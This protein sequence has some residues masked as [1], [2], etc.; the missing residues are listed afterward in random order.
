M[1]GIYL[2]PHVNSTH[3]LI[4]NSGILVICRLRYLSFKAHFFLLFIFYFFFPIVLLLSLLEHLWI[5]TRISLVC[6]SYKISLLSDNC[7]IPC[8]FNDFSECFTFLLPPLKPDCFQVLPWIFR[9]KLS[10]FSYIPHQLLPEGEDSP[11]LAVPFQQSIS[12]YTETKTRL[13]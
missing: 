10:V 5:L 8:K 12:L 6:L 1:C 7:N 3:Y 11:W 4:Q 13:N 9:S 2:L